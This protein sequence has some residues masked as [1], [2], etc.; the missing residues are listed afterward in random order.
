MFLNQNIDFIA[1][2]INSP[3]KVMHSTIDL[4]KYLIKIPGIT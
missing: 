1:I 4:D 2:L 3:P